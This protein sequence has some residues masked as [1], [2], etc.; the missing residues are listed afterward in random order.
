MRKWKW[1]FKK[2]RYLNSEINF[3][4]VKKSNNK[5]FYY[6]INANKKIIDNT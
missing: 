1:Y 4:D 6:K 2:I 5:D 3:N